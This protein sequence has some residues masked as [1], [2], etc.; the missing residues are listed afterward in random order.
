MSEGKIGRRTFL[1]GV[2]S[3]AALGAAGSFRVTGFRARCSTEFRRNES[4]EIEGARGIYVDCHHHIYDPR[5]TAV[6]KPEPNATVAD[7]RLLQKRLGTTRNVIVTP[8]AYGLDNSVTLDALTQSGANARGVAVVHPDVSDADLKKMHDGGIRGIRFSNPNPKGLVTVDMI[9]PLAKR[10]A[11]FGWHIQFN[12]SSD[13]ILANE[14]LLMGLPTKIIF[15]HLGHMLP[16]AGVNQPAFM[17]MRRL[18]DKGHTW[19]KLSVY[20]ADT[21]VGPP[22]Y[23]DLNEVAKAYVEAAPE[24][25]VWGTN[26]PHP[27][28]TPKP[29]DADFLDMLLVSAPKE[30]NA[31]AFWW[32]I[33]KCFTDSRS[34]KIE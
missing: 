29:S 25:M 7:Y 28:E 9:D 4:P 2:G 15:D 10:V 13:L 24:R 20:I 6:G 18:L 3:V 11:D 19:M 17:T 14:S 22:T 27:G 12:M 1:Q 32:K 33:R 8:S 21:K 26:W 34:P 31:I 16:P 30:K 5:F 23:S